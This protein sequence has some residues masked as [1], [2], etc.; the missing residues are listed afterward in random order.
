M[1]KSAGVSIRHIAKTLATCTPV[2]QALGEP[3]RQQIIVM[4]AET[5][6]MN[7]TEIT[8]RMALSRPAVSHHLK[9]LRDA[10][11]VS[12]R[13]AGTENLY[14]LAMADALVLLARLVAN[15]QA[16]DPEAE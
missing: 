3:A 6:E 4:L 11:L 13:R 1:P 10:N 15:V 16:C 14:A 8:G 5:D 12:A 2:F 7:V 9:V